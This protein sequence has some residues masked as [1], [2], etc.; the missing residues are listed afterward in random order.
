[1]PRRAEIS[2]RPVPPDA[3]YNSTLVTQVV[4]KV[5]VKGKKSVAEQIVYEALDRVATKTNRPPAEVLEQAVKSVSTTPG[6]GGRR[7]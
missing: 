6:A 4:N 7:A 2:V 1:M 5:M 3:V